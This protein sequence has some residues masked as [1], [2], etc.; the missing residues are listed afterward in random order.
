V[1]RVLGETGV[2]PA[3]IKLEIT[4]SAIMQNVSEGIATLQALRDLGLTLALD[5]FGT[6]HA[7]L[8]YLQQLP[9]QRL[10]IDQ[11][12]VRALPGSEPDVAIVRTIIEL[13]QRLG[14]RLIA[15][16]V[17]TEQ[18]M[19]LLRSLGCEEIQG[20]L[21]ARPVPAEAAAAYF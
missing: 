16:G 18:Q 13:G 17:E 4:E 8:T 6:G 5:D 12:F 1:A 9:V 19:D 10:K 2:D 7:S 11:S 14:L 20:Y 15:E 3:L 21:Y